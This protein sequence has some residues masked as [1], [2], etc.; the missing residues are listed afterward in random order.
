M[1]IWLL[2]D[3]QK[4]RRIRYITPQKT[5][6]KNMFFLKILLKPQNKKNKNNSAQSREIKYY[7][8]AGKNICEQPQISIAATLLLLSR[9][10]SCFYSNLEHHYKRRDKQ[11][12][13]HCII[14]CLR[15]FNDISQL[16]NERSRVRSR[17]GSMCHWNVFT[18]MMALLHMARHRNHQW[19]N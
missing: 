8:M 2:H 1:N 17:R 13:E 12:M 10:T 15:T 14:K 9:A 16:N 7:P 11:T 6:P 3:P 5:W 19:W 4:W 18:Q